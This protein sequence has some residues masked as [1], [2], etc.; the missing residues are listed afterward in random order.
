MKANWKLALMCLATLAMVACN[1]KNPADQDPTVDPIVDPTVDPIDDTYTPPIDVTDKSLADWDKLDQSKVA[2][3]VL[4]ATSPYWDA[5]KKIQ[6]YADSICIFYAL[7]FD[8]EA[9]T[10][11]TETAGFHIYINAD[12]DPNTGGFWDLFA[13]ANKGNCD[14]MFEGT[15]W[16]AF[17]EQTSYLPPHI[18]YWSGATG[19]DQWNWTEFAQIDERVSMSQFVEDGIVEGYLIR[20]L[21][22]WKKWSDAFEIGFDIYDDNYTEVGLLPQGD[23][24]DGGQQIGRKPKLQVTFDE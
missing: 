12:N 13:P 11:P 10:A 16:N 19:G 8:P 23:A 5:L 24:T 4:T 7:T 21:I 1:D 22:P 9:I 20:D 18:S 6:V 15:L 3:D 14:L 17:G 2:V